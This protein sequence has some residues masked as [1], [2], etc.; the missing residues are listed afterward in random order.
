MHYPHTVT[1]E[2]PVE[3]RT[4]AGGVSLEWEPVDGLE[5]LPA[6]CVPVPLGEG[7]ATG[8]RMT[9]AEDRWTIVVQGDRAIERDMRAVT[10]HV[11][12]PL[13]VVRVQ[14]PVLYGSARTNATIIE[15][16]RI[17]VALPVPGSS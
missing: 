13:S 4:P 17:S 14:R 12:E 11:A 3:G 16:E 2:A 1:F 5:A 8:E 7:E 9:L 6:R 10:D 15:A